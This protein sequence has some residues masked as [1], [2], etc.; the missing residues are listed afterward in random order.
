MDNKPSDKGIKVYQKSDVIFEEDSRGDEMYIVRSGK[1]KLVLEGKRG[2]AEVG[3]LE[4]PGDFFGEMALIDESPRSATAIAEEDNTELE[5]LD[6]ENFLMMIRE[7]PEFALDIMRE[8]SERTRLGNALYTEVVEEAMTPFCRQ[9]CLGKTMDAFTRR[10]MSLSGQEPVSEVTKTVN[11]RCTA[12]DYIYIAEFG[13]PAGGI[14]PG[15]PFEDL[16]DSWKCPECGVP[17]SAFEK[18]EF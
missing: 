3:M 2:G 10:A 17:K 11:W 8:L 16:P 6:R 5:V 1:V 7:H 15:T 14:P 4:Q 9:N 13:D 12:C 18:I